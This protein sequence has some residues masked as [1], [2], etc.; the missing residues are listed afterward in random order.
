MENELLHYENICFRRD[1]RHILD[2][3]NWHIEKGENWALL[4]LNGAGKS[5]LLSMIPAYQI[6]TTGTLRVFGHEF[7]KYAW[8][9]IK[10]RL[11][12]VSSA[13]GQFQSTLDKQVVE[14]VVISGAFSSIGIYQDVSPEVRER[15]MQLFY[16]FGLGHLE[17]H[18]FYTLSA[19]EQRRV[20]L[21][22]SIMANPDLLIL[23][24]PCSGLDLPAREQFLKTVESMARDERKPFIYVSHQIE[25]IMPS[26]THVAIIKDGLIVYKGKKQDILTDDILTDVFGIDVSVV[27]EQDRPWVIVK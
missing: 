10:S 2:N 21:A 27:W 22:R 8:P 14:D 23:D 25:E 7:G 18:R 16:E 13:L 19:G 6:P 4:G 12:F 5:T 3:V 15:G 11:G 9:K 24:E 1:G 20:L 26:I 17:G